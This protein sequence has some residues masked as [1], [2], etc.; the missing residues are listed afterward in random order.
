[1][2]T[3][4]QPPPP[5]PE[6]P[7]KIALTTAVDY[8]KYT[9]GFGTGALV[10]SVGLASNAM[11]LPE[12]SRWLLVMS[13]AFLAVSVV[14]G[15][16]AY[17]RIPVMLAEENYDLEDRYFI[18]PGRI[19]QITFGLGVIWLGIAL[20][21]GIVSSPHFEVVSAKDAVA[22]AISSKQLDMQVLSV[23]KVELLTGVTDTE[24]QRP[25]WHVQL[26]LVSSKIPE[27]TTRSYF[28]DSYSGAV[29][30]VP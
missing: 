2:A 22:V 9:T 29:L 8:I 10:F 20:V 12:S 15:V 11:K 13:W 23:E 28:I 14:G 24:Q 1:M 21:L 26:K 16:L 30:T 18:V 3:T 17:S 25:V 4:D 5:V 27:P 7:G 6:A 19:H